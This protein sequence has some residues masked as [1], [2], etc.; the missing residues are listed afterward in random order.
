MLGVPKAGA[1]GGVQVRAV[2]RELDSCRPP[3]VARHL[4]LTAAYSCT[5]LTAAYSCTAPSPDG[6]LQLRGTLTSRQPTVAR[7]SLR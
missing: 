7:Y 6:S 5:V 3:T 4:N 2:L 1:D